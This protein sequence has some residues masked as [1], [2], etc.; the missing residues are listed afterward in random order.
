MITKLP[1]HGT[2]K[3]GT[4]AIV[5]GAKIP[6]ASISN[7]TYN[8]TPEYNGPDVASWKG[9]DGYSY[10]QNEA[11]I[12]FVIAPA[13]DAPVIDLVETEAFAI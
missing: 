3:L 4:V 13:N 10:S 2:L 9:S 7:L 11:D 12:N 6:S 5:A 1:A 8:P